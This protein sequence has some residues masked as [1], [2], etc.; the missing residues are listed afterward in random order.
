MIQVANLFTS[1]KFVSLGSANNSA[2]TLLGRQTDCAQSFTC[3]AIKDATK[4]I[5][6]YL[7]Y[8]KGKII[9]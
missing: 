9:W 2:T 5:I 7:K 6:S 1:I 8:P 4:T 3:A